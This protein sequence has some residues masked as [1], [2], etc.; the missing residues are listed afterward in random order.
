MLR[1]P[2]AALLARTRRLDGLA[3]LQYHTALS[4]ALRQMASLHALATMSTM[5]L[6]LALAR[7]TARPLQSATPLLEPSQSAS[8]A[9]TSM[10]RPRLAKIAVR[11]R[12]VP[13][14]SLAPM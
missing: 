10:A 1:Q 6:L 13:T 11:A 5:I 9:S 2:L 12:S 14:V 7:V 8:S 3:A 4:K